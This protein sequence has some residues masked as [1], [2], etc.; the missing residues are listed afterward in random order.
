VPATAEERLVAHADNL[1][2]GKRRVTIHDTFA[3]ATHLP[4]KIRRRI[5]R[6]AL[7]VEILCSS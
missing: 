3:Y 7:D 4:R 5:Y 6:L 2:A 1:I